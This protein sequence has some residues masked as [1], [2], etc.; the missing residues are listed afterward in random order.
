MACSI[1]IRMP[2]LRGRG[3]IKLRAMKLPALALVVALCLVPPSVIARQQKRPPRNVQRVLDR[4]SGKGLPKWEYLTLAGY[5]LNG[6]TQSKLDAYG[7]AGW[8][9]ISVINT[10][11]SQY[12]IFF[13]K[14]PRR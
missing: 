3:A 2:C 8:E 4:L 7:D 12:C 6:E 1:S 5:A 10:G 9:L 13:L 11:G 14:R